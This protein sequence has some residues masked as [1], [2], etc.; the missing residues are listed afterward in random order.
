ML[1]QQPKYIAYLFKPAYLTCQ[2]H[3]LASFTEV[4]GHCN[5]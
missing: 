4:L 1:Q 5:L 2:H 3:L